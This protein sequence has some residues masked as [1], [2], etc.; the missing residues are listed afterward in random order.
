MW[1][2]KVFLET[3]LF[4]DEQKAWHAATTGTLEFHSNKQD[5]DVH[6]GT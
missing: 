3:T 2:Q 1:G 6:V 4:F 5:S